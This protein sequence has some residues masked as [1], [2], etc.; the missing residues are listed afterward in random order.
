MAKKIRTLPQGQM[1]SHPSNW[2]VYSLENGP[3]ECTSQTRFPWTGAESAQ[4]YISCLLDSQGSACT[5][6]PSGSQKRWVHHR[7]DAWQSFPQWRWQH[8]CRK[9]EGAPSHLQR[10]KGFQSSFP[11]WRPPQDLFAS[12]KNKQKTKRCLCFRHVLLYSVSTQ[13]MPEIICV[14][15]PIVN[16]FLY[17][18]TTFCCLPHISSSM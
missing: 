8:R 13:M 5:A 2:A 16:M 4:K 12:C 18:W 17:H 1:Q 10:P 6:G 9:M 15:M 3:W 7:D 14:T 11:W